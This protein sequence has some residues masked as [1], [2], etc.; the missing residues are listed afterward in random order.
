MAAEHAP[1]CQLLVGDALEWI[2]YQYRTVHPILC[3]LPTKLAEWISDNHWDVLGIPA[4]RNADGWQHWQ[5]GELNVILENNVVPG[6]A[7]HLRI[8]SSIQWECEVYNGRPKARC[9]AFDLLKHRFRGRTPQVDTYI[10]C[11]ILYD[12]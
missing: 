11:Y 6:T 5:V 2:S 10:I 1:G 9:Y 4:R 8:F 12:I 3:W 7:G